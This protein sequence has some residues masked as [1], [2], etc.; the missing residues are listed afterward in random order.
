LHQSKKQANAGEEEAYVKKQELLDAVKG[1]KLEGDH[2]E[3]LALI[4]EHIATWKSIGRVPYAKRKIDELFNKELDNL[5]GQL[6]IDKKE[7]EMIRYENRMQSMAGDNDANALEK[8][9]FFITKKVQEIKAEINQLENNLGF[10]QHV[11]DD[12][13]LVK[14]VHKNINNHKEALAVWVAKL[15]KIKQ[16]LAEING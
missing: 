9:R 16:V 1:L 3:N 5:F 14:E 12:N 10:F 8:E 11:P 15:R 4:K 7:S 6:D 2:Q 13:P